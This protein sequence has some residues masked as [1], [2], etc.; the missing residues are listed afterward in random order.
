[1][2]LIQ[3]PRQ[4]RSLSNFIVPCIT[5]QNDLDLG[6]ETFGCPLSRNCFSL[7]DSACFTT[8]PSIFSSL[9][10]FPSAGSHSC[11]V[12][13]FTGSQE[14]LRA[15]FS[16]HIKPQPSFISTTHGSQLIV[17]PKAAPQ[18]SGVVPAGSGSLVGPPPPPELSQQQRQLAAPSPFASPELPASPGRG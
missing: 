18:Q 12:L 13:V 11:T 7:R 16:L 5:N 17:L 8:C 4:C 10:S 9:L 2:K 3:R 15:A 14:A 6:V 1:M